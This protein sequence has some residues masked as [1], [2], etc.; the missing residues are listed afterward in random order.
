MSL[1]AF[2]VQDFQSYHD[3][4]TVT[5]DPGLTLIA[6]R[7]T[8]G[9]SALLRALRIFVDAQQGAG[10][11]LELSYRWN[12]VTGRR[13]W[14]ARVTPPMLTPRDR[15]CGRRGRPRQAAH[16]GLGGARDAL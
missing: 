1:T 15:E 3:P 12:F 13:A 5:I 4:Q 9:K 6:G 7:N 2:A 16:A 10:P 11:S 8:V 14:A